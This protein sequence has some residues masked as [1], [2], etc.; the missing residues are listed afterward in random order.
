MASA[1][2]TATP[3]AVDRERFRVLT[4]QV[5]RVL[6]RYNLKEKNYFISVG[7]IEKKKNILALIKAFEP[8]E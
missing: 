4:Q 1:K 5:V 7:R 2:L 8:I 3:L 6:Q